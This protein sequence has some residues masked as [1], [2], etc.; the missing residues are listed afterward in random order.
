[1]SGDEPP[2]TRKATN[3]WVAILVT[4]INSAFLGG[5]LAGAV[6]LYQTR[7]ADTLRLCELATTFLTDDAKD[8][9]SLPDEE[10][11]TLTRFYISVA[12]ANCRED[13]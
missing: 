12:Q 3:R 11:A 10:W 7:N 2:A 5:V 6:T 13:G 1:M 4:I 8:R 9:R